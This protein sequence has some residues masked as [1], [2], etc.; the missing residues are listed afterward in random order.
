MNIATAFDYRC[1]PKSTA[2]CEVQENEPENARVC[3]RSLRTYASVCQMS[4]LM[5]MNLCR[6]Y[7]LGEEFQ[8][9]TACRT[10]ASRCAGNGSYY[11][12][13]NDL[14]SVSSVCME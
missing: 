14:M 10:P 13:R 12:S 6:C 3:H 7:C 1:S 9:E 5:I 8:P 11:V 2:A 4:Y